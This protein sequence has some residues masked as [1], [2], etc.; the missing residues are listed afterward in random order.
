MGEAALESAHA[1]NS[2]ALLKIVLKGHV[3][4]QGQ[5]KRQIAVF[6]WFG[7]WGR[8]IKVILA[9]TWTKYS[10]SYDEGTMGIGPIK[11]LKPHPWW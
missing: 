5:V 6:S 11:S 3:S 1:D 7:I 8:H 4:G 9:Q 10:Q 2:K